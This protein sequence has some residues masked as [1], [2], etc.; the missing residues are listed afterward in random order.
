MTKL[1]F[2]NSDLELQLIST[3]KNL[4]G[5]ARESVI[6]KANTELVMLNWNI[7]KL[8]RIQI[9]KNDR[10]D[11]GEQIVATL[12]Q[13]L[14]LEYG[15]GFTKSSLFRM[16]QF[17]ELFPHEEIVATLSR[18]LGWS[19][20]VELIPIEDPLK[21]EFYVELCRTERW[22]VRT[23]RD[24]IQGMLF[25]RT[26]ISKKPEL[27]IKKDLEILRK[28]G[29]PTTSIVLRDPFSWSS[30]SLKILIVSEI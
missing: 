18:Q 20:F 23:L 22:S 15:K 24:K 9:Q 11:Y 2:S 4:I 7:G 13:Q 29:K 3:I 14:S 26:A 30:W 8:I 25:E 16:V 27:T 5:K 10:A 19:H 17:Y 12:S 1:S 21:R 6:S 28:T